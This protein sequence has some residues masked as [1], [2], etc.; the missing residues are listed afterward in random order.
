ME[1]M[2]D[3]M[4]LKKEKSIRLYI[5]DDAVSF[6][7]MRGCVEE[8]TSMLSELSFDYS[9]SIGWMISVEEGSVALRAYPE[10]ESETLNEKEIAGFL[11]YV[12]DGITSLSQGVRPLNFP[13]KAVKDYEKLATVLT[14]E[15]V[16][17]S[18]IEIAG[19]TNSPKIV[20]VKPYIRPAR[21]AKP[22]D[23]IQSIGSVEG[24]VKAI[25]GVGQQ[26]IDVYE[27]LSARKVKVYCDERVNVDIIRKSY[28]N[29]V[30]ATGVVTYDESGNKMSVKASSLSIM[31]P[32]KD[33]A[34]L[35]DLSGILE[36]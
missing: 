3:T 32:A 20:D 33:S 6:E 36:A 35:I 13:E 4:K 5:P 11:D 27:D 34:S 23:N 17:K 30:R 21:V 1:E 31:N 12:G 2:G 28:K 9:S 16:A 29:R 25:H 10:D 26:F 19:T 8:F 14:S 15:N 7:V 18:R 22:V 24:T